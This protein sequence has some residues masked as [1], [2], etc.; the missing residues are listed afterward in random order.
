[1]GI[2]FEQKKLPLG[3]PSSSEDEEDDENHSE[4]EFIAV[5][6]RSWFYILMERKLRFFYFGFDVDGFDK[7]V[8][9]SWKDAPGDD[10]NAMRNLCGRA[11]DHWKNC[12]DKGNGSDEMLTTVLEI[13]GKLQQVNKAQA[14][15]NAMMQYSG[16]SNDLILTTLVH[17]G[18]AFIVFSGLR[19]NVVPKA[20]LW[21]TPYV[22]IRE[23]VV[24][25]FQKLDNLSRLVSTDVTT[26][27]SAVVSCSKISSGGMCDYVEVF[28]YEEW[29]HLV[30]ISLGFRQI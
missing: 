6:S 16:N 2:G 10:S 3:I 7:F 28:S 17:D 12:I 30:G 13:L 11:T 1:K 4:H 27:Q 21:L 8:T 23:V 29:E 14:S 18:N 24:E 9:D 20:R 26:S 15:R 25:D 19:V 5:N 22:G